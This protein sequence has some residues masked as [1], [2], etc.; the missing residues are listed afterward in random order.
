MKCI[1]NKSADGY[2][3]IKISPTSRRLVHGILFLQKS[4]N[5]KKKFEG[6]ASAL[7]QYASHVRQRRSYIYIKHTHKAKQYRYQNGTYVL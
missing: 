3:V 6:M 4:K 5:T 7:E 1:E 2:F